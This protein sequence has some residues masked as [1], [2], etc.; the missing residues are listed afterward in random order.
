M[1]ADKLTEINYPRQTSEWGRTLID[2][3][4][5]HQAQVQEQIQSIND[6]VNDKFENFEK[7]ID[8][9]KT[10]AVTA[11]RLAEQNKKDIDEIRDYLHFKCDQ[12]SSENKLLKQRTNKLENY[13][14]R[15]NV[16]IKGIAEPQH[17][18][19]QDCEDKIRHFLTTQLKLN[20]DTVRNM[21]FVR[22]HRLGSYQK[23]RFIGTKPNRPIIVRFRDYADKSM[24]WAARSN[25]SND[26]L[27]ISENFS[28]ETEYNRKKLYIIYKYAKSLEKYKM[29]I[30]LNGDNLII[31]S[32]YYTVDNLCD[33]PADLSPR[34]FCEKSDDKYLIFGG[35]ISEHS[36]FSNWYPCEINYKDHPF[37][38][39]EQAYQYAKAIH[40][41]DAAIAG[42]LLF[43]TNPYLAK[44]LGSKVS[45]LQLT[46]WDQKK[47]EVMME[48]VK[49]KFEDPGLRNILIKTDNKHLVES[50]A[51][52]HY[53]AGLPFTSKDIYIQNKWT[54]QNKLGAILC[55][56]RKYI[57]DHL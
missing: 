46:D 7:H 35:I 40:C 13:S 53:A 16:V 4:N 23:G 48:L 10:T 22:V 12:L 15:N 6:N 20:E 39:I 56:V 47:M 33:L 19:K 54:G 55:D 11:L 34:L 21:K 27:F 57:K 44:N 36:P 42:K 50:G 29:K 45:G 32:V 14:R 1:S 26:S 28:A 2:T 52:K 51:D 49:I 37:K 38:N 41:D 17:E 18:T 3:L 25:I 30:S 9:I 5:A 43:T 8:E 31:D 24:V